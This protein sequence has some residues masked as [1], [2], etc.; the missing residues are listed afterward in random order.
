MAYL[1][2]CIECGNRVSSQAINCPSCKAPQWF[3]K[4]CYVC[5]EKIK[6]T[7][8][9]IIGYL[10]LGFRYSTQRR[11]LGNSLSYGG[12][13]ITGQYEY[14]DYSTDA[15]FHAHCYSEITALKDTQLEYSGKCS[16][17]K[18]T[19]HLSVS[20]QSVCGGSNRKV[21]NNIY[22]S[23]HHCGHDSKLPP[24]SKLERVG[25]MNP[26]HQCV[27]CGYN[28]DSRFSISLPFPE[29]YAHQICYTSERSQFVENEKQEL[30]EGEKAEL[31]RRREIEASKQ[32]EKN[33]DLQ[34]K[35]VAIFIAILVMWI[36]FSIL[37]SLGNPIG[38]TILMVITFPFVWFMAW[39]LLC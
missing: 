30:Q 14:C 27:F 23:C 28:L 33:K 16:V 15:N 10:P 22:F 32:R 29:R 5:G 34:Q 19:V 21:E 37:Y 36:P 18:N 2:N 25:N 39:M 4:S 13:L 3:A 11:Y 17:C 35:V 20:L 9:A 31:E 12:P 1:S 7:E 6:Q 26:Y 38:V 8:E 24:T